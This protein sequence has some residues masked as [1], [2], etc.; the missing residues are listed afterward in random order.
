MGKPTGFLEIDRKLAPKRAVNERV[1]DYKEIE[2]LNSIY[3]HFV[4]QQSTLQRSFV[5]RG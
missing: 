2:Q 1:N 4:P 5:S 3:L